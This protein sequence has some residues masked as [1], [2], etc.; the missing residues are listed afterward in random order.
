MWYD[1]LEPGRPWA[2][3]WYGYIICR[4]GGIRGLTGNCPVC[5]VDVDDVAARTVR[6]VDGR[7]IVTNTFMGAEG[8]HEDYMYL[9]LMEREWNRPVTDADRVAGFDPA[10]Q[11][12]PRAGIVVQF[13]SYFETRIERLL[14]AGMRNLP[15]RITE[16]LLS[17]YTVIGARLDRLYGI[18]FDATYRGDLNDLGFASVAQHLALVQQRRNA[19]AHGDPHAID[20]ALVE[21]VVENLKREHEAWIAVFNHRSVR[22]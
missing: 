3:L 13:W 22:A 20:D 6:L 9:N 2:A 15:P 11:P 19:F 12:S 16:D 21:A 14:R 18:L 8:R 5:G 17:R 1:D 7:E 10:R 4:C